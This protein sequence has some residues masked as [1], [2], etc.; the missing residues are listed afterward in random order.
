MSDPGF[1]VETELPFAWRPGTG[2]AG[3]ERSNLLLLHVANQID[4]RET[5]QDESER[6]LEAKLDLLLHWLGLQLFGGGTAPSARSIAL[7]GLAAEWD[8]PH[9]TCSEGAG[10]LSLI[11]HPDLPGPL[12]L[13]GRLR[14]DGERCHVVFDLTDGEAKEAWHRWLFRLHRRA[15]HDARNKMAPD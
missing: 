5:E 11:I 1:I 10:L 15:I 3:D 12:N 7:S 8:D 9:G 2:N 13:A 4:T 6:R 14:R